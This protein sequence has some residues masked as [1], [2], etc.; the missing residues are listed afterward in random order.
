M[1]KIFEIV[2]FTA[3]LCKYADAIIDQIDPEGYITSRLYR[4]NCHK[5]NSQY[6]KD[7]SSIGRNLKNVILIDNSPSSFAL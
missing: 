2:V 7:L 4:E 3:S 5:I 1:A 6:T